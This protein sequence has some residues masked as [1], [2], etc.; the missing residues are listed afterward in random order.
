MRFARRMFRPNARTESPSYFIA[1]WVTDESTRVAPRRQ[2]WRSCF[3]AVDAERWRMVRNQRTRAQCVHHETTEDWWEWFYQQLTIERPLWVWCFDLTRVATL[4]K[5]WEELDHSRLKHRAACLSA[6][7]GYI[8]LEHERGR[9]V[10]LD[11]RNWWRAAPPADAHPAAKAGWIADKVSELWCVTRRLNLGVLR[12]TAAGQALQ[13]YRHR[14]GPRVQEKYI[15]TRGRFA[16]QERTRQIVLPKIHNHQEAIDL[17]E[18]ALHGGPVHCWQ[19]GKVKG[20]VYVLDCQSLYP[21]VMAQ[22]LFPCRLIDYGVSP[23]SGIGARV[24]DPA[25]SIARV[26]LDCKDEFFPLRTDG[27]T[28]YPVGRFET[29][30]AGPELAKAYQLGAVRRAWEVA[31]YEMRDLFSKYV[32]NLW[33]A[34][35][36]YTLANQPEW[37]ET[38]K[39]ILNALHGKFAQRQAEWAEYRRNA[40]SPRW[41]Y[42]Y[43]RTSDILPPLFCRSIA[44]Q[45]QVSQRKGWSDHAFPAITAFVYSYARQWMEQFFRVARAGELWYS[46]IDSLHCDQRA[47]EAL[48]S[49]GLVKPG[50]L[51]YLRPVGE[52]KSA[53]YYGP[54]DYELD[55]VRKQSGTPAGAK[56]NCNGELSWLEHEPAAHI[57]ERGPDGNLYTQMLRVRRAR[58]FRWGRVQRDGKVLPLEKHS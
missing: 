15:P 53:V 43:D 20:P 22:N 52:A 29:T 58:K 7:V 5:L 41:G 35:K 8:S 6:R 16:G 2:K 44:G 50:Q 3:A 38:V 1:L 14:F 12:L 11:C 21:Y 24:D 54:N 51:G 34:R 26:E 42:W 49:A 9:A 47:K 56:E 33:C 39:M 13:V 48:E 32:D 37:A 28:V 36:V 17:E 19:L 23:G 45:P 27:V 30:L 55:G 40:P 18:K 46:A 25:N 31:R 4:L 10:W 57:I